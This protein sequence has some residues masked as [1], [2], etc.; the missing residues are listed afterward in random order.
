MIFQFS[1]KRYD[2]ILCSME[3]HVYSL[4]KSSC[5]ELF[6]DK[7]YGL[8]FSQKVDG[9]MILNFLEMGNAVFF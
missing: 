2:D 3:N 9:N 7:K 1:K 4:L 5:F 8:Y 6:G